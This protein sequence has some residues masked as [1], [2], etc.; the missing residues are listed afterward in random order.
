[1]E[2]APIFHGGTGS[3]SEEKDQPKVRPSRYESG[4]LNTPGIAGLSAGIDEVMKR[5]V[6]TIFEHEWMLT[7]YSLDKLSDIDGVTVFGPDLNV[8]RLAVIP[9]IIDGTD[10]QEIAMIFDQHYQ[11]ALRGGLHCAPLAHETIG[12]I[13]GGTL[14]ASFGLYNTLEEI[15]QWLGMI[16]E[17]KEGLVG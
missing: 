12:T 3:H 15:D 8:E 4:T 16:K 14:R 1:M 2:L 17:I 10:V 5:G 9:F 7:K 13:E 11:V 6:E